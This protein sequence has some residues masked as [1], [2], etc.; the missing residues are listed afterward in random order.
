MMRELHR[1]SMGV[2]SV[3]A[4]VEYFQELRTFYIIIRFYVHDSSRLKVKYEI[5]NYHILPI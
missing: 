2:L 5:L 1:V 4:S 3:V